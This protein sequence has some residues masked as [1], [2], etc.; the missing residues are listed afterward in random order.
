[1]YVESQISTIEILATSKSLSH[2]VDR[3]QARNAVKNK[4]QDTLLRITTLQQELA[5]QKV[6][7][8]RLLAEQQAQEAQ[9]SY[10]RGEQA[11]LLNYNKTQQKEYNKQMAANTERITDLKEAQAIENARLFGGSGGVLGGGGYPWGY[12][13]CIH[14]GT[15]EGRCPNYDWAVNGQIYNWET[16]G[17]GYR[18]CTDWVSYRI[19][20][21]GG[22][23]PSGLGDAKHWDDRAGAYGYATSSVPRRG[24]AAVSNS[25]TYGHVMYV[26]VLE[27]SGSIL[28]SDYNGSG[29]GLYSTTM[30][31]RISDGRYQNM[32]SGAISTLTFIYF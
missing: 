4:I 26:E 15:L 1:M 9:L 17:Y 28:I 24:A 12:A 31:E 30:L 14:N 21:T 13:R 32:R 2:F 16:G 3:E 10:N 5:T 20:S 6:E 23:V 25:G 7:V 29:T 27:D 22:Y 8:E 11:K 19:R 18:N